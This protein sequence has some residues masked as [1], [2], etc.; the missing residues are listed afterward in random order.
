MYA[1]ISAF[2]NADCTLFKLLCDSMEGIAIEDAAVKFNM[3]FRL[4]GIRD[5]TIEGE[6]D[7]FGSL[8]G[9]NPSTGA[10]SESAA[11]RKTARCVSCIFPISCVSIDT[12]SAYRIG[13]HQGNDRWGSG[14]SVA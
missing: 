14:S 13:W 4:H 12:G 5:L 6:M 3:M 7:V 1:T 11:A 10:A 8:D 9:I 2:T